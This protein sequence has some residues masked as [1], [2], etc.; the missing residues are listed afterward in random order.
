L[1]V[2]LLALAEFGK[3]EEWGYAEDEEEPA[4]EEGVVGERRGRLERCRQFWK[5]LLIVDCDHSTTCSCCWEERRG[6]R[7]VG[8]REREGRFGDDGDGDGDDGGEEDGN[9]VWRV[10]VIIY[11]KL[12]HY[13]K[14]T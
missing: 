11:M 10:P 1:A 14:P 8:Q 9:D 2:L 12:L 7:E 3:E 6:E 13:S 5:R 4:A